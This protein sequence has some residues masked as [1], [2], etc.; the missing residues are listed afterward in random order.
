VGVHYGLQRTIQE[1]LRQARPLVAI[2]DPGDCGAIERKIHM[3]ARI[4]DQVDVTPAVLSARVLK[5]VSGVVC[6]DI[7]LV[8]QALAGSCRAADKQ[9][10]FSTSSAS[11]QIHEALIDSS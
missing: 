5:P 9:T 1:D 3:R 7:G 11:T 2:A 4:N 6:R 10:P 8:H